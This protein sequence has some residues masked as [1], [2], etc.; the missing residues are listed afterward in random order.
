VS[1]SGSVPGNPEPGVRSVPGNPEPGVRSVPRNPER[2]RHFVLCVVEHVGVFKYTFPSISSEV[3]MGSRVPEN[4]NQKRVL[5]SWEREPK[6][7]SQE[8]GT[9]LQIAENKNLARVPR[10]WEPFLGSR[11]QEPGTHSNLA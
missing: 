7:G 6:K 10:S 4:E 8:R 1:V 11:P 3:A 5:G 2:T 9:L